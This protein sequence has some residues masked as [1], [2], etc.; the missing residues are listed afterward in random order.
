[1]AV[2]ALDVDL[3]AGSR[4]LLER[5]PAGVRTAPATIHVS[6]DAD[7]EPA[8]PTRRAGG[9]SVTSSMPSSVRATWSITSMTPWPTS[10]AA[11]RTSAEPSSQEHARGA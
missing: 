6:R 10:A 5:G 1:M 7:A 4:S 8:E 11:Q 3:A 9:A 2:D